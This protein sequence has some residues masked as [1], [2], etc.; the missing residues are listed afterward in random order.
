MGRYSLPIPYFGLLGQ[1]LLFGFLCFSRVHI[2]VLA[3]SCPGAGP[4][5]QAH[6]PGPTHGWHIPFQRTPNFNKIAGFPK[7][8]NSIHQ[9]SMIPRFHESKNPGVQDSL[10]SMIPCSGTL[11]GGSG[12]SGEA[13]WRLSG[14]SLVAGVALGGHGAICASKVLFLC[15]TASAGA[16]SNFV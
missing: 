11:S 14:S 1:L 3:K 9:D 10:D 15:F 5:S 6:D 13:I 16:T 4:M 8:Q 2:R 7:F 12:C